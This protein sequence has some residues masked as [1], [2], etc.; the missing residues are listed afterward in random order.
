MN[1]SWKPIGKAKRVAT[2]DSEHAKDR[3][4]LDS[5]FVLVTPKK[6][7]SIGTILLP[8]E[9]KELGE[10]ATKQD[11]KDSTLQQLTNNT[12]EEDDLAKPST[13]P[14]SNINLRRRLFNSSN[15]FEARPTTDSSFYSPQPR[16]LMNIVSPYP[17][18]ALSAPTTPTGCTEARTNGTSPPPCYPRREMTY[19]E[20]PPE[21]TWIPEL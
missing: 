15:P 1:D 19:D 11:H 20:G 5:A 2:A 13:L 7:N 4:E 14:S 17:Y 3:C 6:A 8:R 10:V 12:W 9:P 16:S 18:D 21:H